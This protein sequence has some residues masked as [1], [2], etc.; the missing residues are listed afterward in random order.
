[1][2]ALL[3]GTSQA[4]ARRHKHSHKLS[5]HNSMKDANDL[6][7][8]A[9]K[10]DFEAMGPEFFKLYGDVK[11]EL[12]CQACQYMTVTAQEFYDSWFPEWLIIELAY[13]LCGIV[14]PKLELRPTVCKGIIDD[15]FKDTI[16]PIIRQ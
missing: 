1:M 12:P 7:Y 4:E 13:G 8:S 9:M 3:Y 15:Q 11:T 10:F 5:F 16:L 2:A 6:A 14:V